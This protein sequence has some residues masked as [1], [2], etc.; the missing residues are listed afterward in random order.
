MSTHWGSCCIRGIEAEVMGQFE[1][2]I[3]PLP[4]GPKGIR[5]GAVFLDMWAISK[6]SKHPDAAWEF[7]EVSPLAGSDG[8]GW[9][10]FGSSRL[11]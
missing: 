9:W 6:S 10:E 2:D 5:Q 3:A 11:T 8:D 4:V 7:V 1:W